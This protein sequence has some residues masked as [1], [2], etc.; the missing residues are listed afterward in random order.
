M[1]DQYSEAQVQA[2]AEAFAAG[3]RIEA[4]RIVEAPPPLA[5]EPM[6]MRGV[7]LSLGMDQRVKAAAEQA[8]VP[9]SALI[10][11]WIELGLSEMEN[12]HTVS[13]AAIRRAIAHAAALDQA[14]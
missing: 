9:F 14:A 4:S 2:A 1:A 10:R 12:D 8:G 5:D 11:Q 13:L 6:V 7:R 3:A